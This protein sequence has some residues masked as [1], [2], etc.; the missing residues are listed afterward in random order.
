MSITNKKTTAT[1]LVTVGYEAPKWASFATGE[2]IQRG[3]RYG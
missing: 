2:N 3:R 1:F